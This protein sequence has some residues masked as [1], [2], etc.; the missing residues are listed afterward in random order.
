MR[1]LLEDIRNRT[2]RAN[3]WYDR[4]QPTPRFML[5]LFGF[6]L[7]FSICLAFPLSG[8]IAILLACM[9]GL[10]RIWYFGEAGRRKKERGED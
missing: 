10:M 9:A 6:A 4:L 1:N 5:F 8:M 3:K 7:P 2:F